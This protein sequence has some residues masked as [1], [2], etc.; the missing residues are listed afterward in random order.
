MLI[1][2]TLLVFVA[3]T[4]TQIATF[5][6]YVFGLSSI[7]P[8]EIVFLTIGSLG[9]TAAFL[10]VIQLKKSI[11]KRFANGVFFSQFGLWLVMY[12]IWFL[13]LREVRTLAL[14]C[15][16]MALAFLLS[17]ARLV[18]SIAITAAATVIQIG[19]SYYAINYLNQPGSFGLEVCYA[20]C[21]LP[22]ALFICALSRQ[23]ARQ[24]LEV[25]DAKRQAETSR[26]ALALETEKAHRLNAELREAADKIREISIRD[27]LTGLYNR[28]HLMDM[29]DMAKQRFERGGPCF[30]VAILDVDYFKRINDTYGHQVGDEVLQHV[31]NCMQASLRGTDLCARFGGEE[32]MLVLEQ[33]VDT[34][35]LAVAERVR[36]MVESGAYSAQGT[37]F[38]VTASLGVASYRQ[39]EPIAQTISR[40]D[41]AL[42]RAKDAGRNRVMYG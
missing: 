17:T 41:A 28:R 8:G 26:D 31:A 9:S 24:R 4:I 38:A 21:F 23:Y 22:S 40:A 2:Y 1:K 37:P 7:R 10:G 33:A 13:A 15:A 30:S 20:L 18:Q 19:G 5:C 14:F 6:A 25:V 36:A 3:Y 34:G 32:F 29:L 11:S 27:V 12:S 16:L 42:Y 35:A 39:G